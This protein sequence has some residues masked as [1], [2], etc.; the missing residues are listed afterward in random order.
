[1][2]ARRSALNG[3]SAWEREER[4]T[5]QR[6]Y[7]AQLQEQVRQ[8]HAK[9]EQ[10]KVRRQQEQRDELEL[11]ERE[12][13]PATRK[14]QPQL[15]QTATEPPLPAASPHRAVS[16]SH[17]P[18]VQSQQGVPT[19]SPLKSASAG[20]G[21]SGTGIGPGVPTNE[22]LRQN[23]ASMPTTNFGPESYTPAFSSAPSI[24]ESILREPGVG[25]RSI[26]FYEDL[27]ALQ[28]LAGELDSAARQRRTEAQ[29]NYVKP[30]FIYQQEQKETSTS[31][32]S[33]VTISTTAMHSPVK[34]SGDKITL[35]DNQL[36]SHHHTASQPRMRSSLDGLLGESVL[37][38]LSSSKLPPS[39]S[40]SKAKSRA[41]QSPMKPL[42][43]IAAAT[44]ETEDDDMTAM[45]ALDTHSELLH[46]MT[47][48]KS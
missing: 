19:A 40:Y 6:D 15:E 42:Q 35:E 17:M 33:P 24:F 38:P 32:T 30:N 43:Q 45:D 9:Q 4:A 37:L 18:I 29:S 13:A 22:S 23:P 11:L 10:E 41:D 7:A 16:M 28:R 1:M 14:H 27:S 39:F 5:Q 48:P 2:A 34:F 8:K 44:M 46:F 3:A 25:A 21:F 47:D 31:T 36:D 12:R 26:A 20:P